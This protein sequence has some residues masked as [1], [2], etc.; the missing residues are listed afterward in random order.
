MAPKPAHNPPK[1]IGYLRVSTG[2]QADSG[3]GL[4]AQ[5]SAIRKEAEH[6][7]WE[8]EIVRDE[9]MSAKS[10]NRPGLKAAMAKL[11]A[12]EADILVVAKLD[13]VSRSVR[14]GAN[15][16]TSAQENGWSL[17]ALDL[18]L[19]MSTPSGRLQYNLLLSVAEF[20][21]DIISARTKAALAERK[22]KPRKTRTLKLPDDVVRRMLAARRDGVSMAQIAR[23]L[24]TE[25]VPTARPGSHWYASTV[26]AVL[27]S[28]RAAELA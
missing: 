2:E 1:A 12:G 7:G 25:G 3:L 21:K 11:D 9:G 4:K 16:A 18:G 13:R 8:L 24:E 27:K 28:K 19:D 17:V 5:E 6:R 23:D 20:E 26:A 15:L 22:G 14:D 10:L